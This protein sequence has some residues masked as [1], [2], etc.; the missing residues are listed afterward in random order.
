MIFRHEV[1]MGRDS[2]YPI[3]TD[4]EKKLARLLK[5]LNIVRTAYGK[6]MNVT[7]GYRPGKYNKAAGGATKSAH[8]T[9]EACDFADS[10][11]ALAKWCLEN[12]GVLEKAGLWMES[13]ARTKGWVHLQTRPVRHRVF[14]P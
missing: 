11:G 9:L 10:T 3:T 5:A 1:L 7:S 8:L 12:L 4:L 6:P 2:E 13:P 14:E